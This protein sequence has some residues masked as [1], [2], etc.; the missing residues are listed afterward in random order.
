MK[1]ARI[2][3]YTPADWFGRA[4]SW[5]LE[6][7]YCH[8]AIEMDDVVFSATYPHILMLPAGQE[9]VAQPPR[10]GAVFE[11]Q[12]TEAQFEATKHWCRARVG[13]DYDWLSI[14]GW[15]FRIE[16]FQLRYGMYCFEFV[17]AALG[18]AGLLPVT[19]QFVSGDE[20]VAMLLEHGA[21]QVRPAAIMAGGSACD[22]SAA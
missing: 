9:D 16:S 2:R 12:M 19:K 15:L 22:R 5:R 4:I 20:L 1:T 8:A 6:S 7:R 11:L 14:I 3:L 10:G 18:A 13:R 21:T 17:L